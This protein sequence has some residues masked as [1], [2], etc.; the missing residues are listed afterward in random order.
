MKSPRVYLADMLAY[1]ARLERIQQRGQSAFYQ[2]EILQDAA[3]RAYEVLGE[4]A[5]RLPTALLDTQPAVDWRSLKGFRDFLA[6][7]YDKVEVAI[8]WDILSDLPALRAAVEA[9]LASLPPEDAS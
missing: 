9:L 7:S 1:V 2:E 4:I 5:K 6:H 3:I 8:L